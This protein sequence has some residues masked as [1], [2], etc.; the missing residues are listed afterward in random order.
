MPL[1][2][3][4]FNTYDSSNNTQTTVSIVRS[5]VEPISVAVHCSTNHVGRDGFNFLSYYFF[6][7]GI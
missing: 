3:L 7:E 4:W 2:N 5:V 6:L 1:I